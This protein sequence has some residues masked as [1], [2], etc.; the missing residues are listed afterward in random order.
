MTEVQLE[1]FKLAAL[2]YIPAELARSF[3][4]PAKV[5]VEEFASF[6]SDDIV[7]RV[8]QAVY[9]E[10]LERIECEWPADWW[11]A[12][13]GRWFPDWALAR[14]PVRHDGA[15]L[16]ARAMYPKVSMPDECHKIVFVREDGIPGQDEI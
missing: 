8:R 5:D 9:G 1:R 12:F 14:W 2:A 4:C 11:Q 15:T 10:T 13:K 6:H 16:E 7:F 3:A